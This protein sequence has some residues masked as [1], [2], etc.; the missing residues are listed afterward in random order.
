MTEYQR[1]GSQNEERKRKNKKKIKFLIGFIVLSLVLV[2]AYFL[3]V[4][5]YLD[6]LIIK[7]QIEGLNYCK[8]LVLYNAQNCTIFQVNLGNVTSNLINVA[9][10]KQG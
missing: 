7:S 1:S 2:G 10:L 4:K 8:A 9:C 5:P 6:N 3:L